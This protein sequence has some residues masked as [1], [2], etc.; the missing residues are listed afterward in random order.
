MSV[1]ETFSQG[2][3]SVSP[4]P[5]AKSPGKALPCAHCFP[6]Y[7]W[8]YSQ[9]KKLSGHTGN[10]YMRSTQGF[11]QDLTSQK[12]RREFQKP[13]QN[14]LAPIM[15]SRKH[16]LLSQQQGGSCQAQGSREPSFPRLCEGVRNGLPGFFQLCK[17]QCSG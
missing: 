16:Y 3:F 13:E 5:S 10:G 1:S 17:A 11:L 4:C 7:S 15:C 2:L 8:E 14:L 6:I 12:P 9:S